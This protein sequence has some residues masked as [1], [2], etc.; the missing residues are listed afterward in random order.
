MT[1]FSAICKEVGR[2]VHIHPADVEAVIGAWLEAIIQN[3]IRD[4]PCKVLDYGTF[5]VAKE[6]RKPRRDPVTHQWGP[7]IQILTPFWRPSNT[8][9]VRISGLDY[10]ETTPS[11]EPDVPEAPDKDNT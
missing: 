4:N 9:L 10:D 6:M 11:V 8:L 3:G 7:A 1:T 2:R 5:G